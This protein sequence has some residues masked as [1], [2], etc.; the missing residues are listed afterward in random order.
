MTKYPFFIVDCT[1]HW[2]EVGPNLP[3]TCN[4]VY[5][6]TLQGCSRYLTEKHAVVNRTLS[7]FAAH[8]EYLSWEIGSPLSVDIAG[9]WY[10]IQRGT[11]TL[12]PCHMR[13]F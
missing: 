13:D 11:H 2:A 4:V 5:Q 8:R 6:G 12:G 3:H 1:S 9:H 10:I 7:D